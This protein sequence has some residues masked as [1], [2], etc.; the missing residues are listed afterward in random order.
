MLRL[1]RK[2]EPQANDLAR[3]LIVLD[4]VAAEGRATPSRPL[5][6][7]FSLRI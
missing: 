2:R 3:L 4:A 1:R 7:P 6:R 5:R